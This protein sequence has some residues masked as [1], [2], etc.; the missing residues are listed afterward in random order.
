MNCQYDQQF[1]L[2]LFRF[3]SL[4]YLTVKEIS[5][6]IYFILQFK[7]LIKFELV[8]DLMPIELAYEFLKG[9]SV[10]SLKN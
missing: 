3:Q 2:D 6:Q 9:Q 10:L 8:S 7:H 1:Y 4:W 5:G